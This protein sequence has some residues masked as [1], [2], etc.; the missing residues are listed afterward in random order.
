MQFAHCVVS[1]YTHTFTDIYIAHCTEMELNRKKDSPNGILVIEILYHL[2][3]N[4]VENKQSATWLLSVVNVV[5]IGYRGAF[6]SVWLPGT[7][8]LRF[9]DQENLI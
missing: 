8:E 1:F 3:W 2:N 4:I 6:W 5:D 9:D 7:M